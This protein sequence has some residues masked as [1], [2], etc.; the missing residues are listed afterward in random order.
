MKTVLERW[1]AFLAESQTSTT[2]LPKAAAIV[3]NDPSYRPVKEI[4]KKSK[5]LKTILPEYIPQGHAGIVLLQQRLD[6]LFIE[7]FDFGIGGT[8]CPKANPKGAIETISQKAG[9]FVDGGVRRRRAAKRYESESGKNISFFDLKDPVPHIIE[10]LRKSSLR[11]DKASQFGY[12]PDINFEAARTY[13]TTPR[14]RLYTVIPHLGDS[15]G[16]NCGSFALKVAAAGMESASVSG[17][18]AAE[19]HNIANNLVGPDQVLP[20]LQKQKWVT[21]AMSF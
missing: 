17:V 19:A 16:D 9:L 2:D 6:F 21:I 4:K 11:T 7:A 13:A 5:F 14:C 8:T 18:R 15:S 1:R 10:I 12:I 3:W 20:I